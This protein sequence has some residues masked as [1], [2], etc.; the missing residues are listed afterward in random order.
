[1]TKVSR[2]SWLK[3]LAAIAGSAVGTRVAGGSWFPEAGAA[4]S[5]KA[6]VVS[7]FFEG[8]FNALFSS[9]DSFAG[10][11]AFG[12]T[13]S[14]AK[15]V[16]GGLVVD[17][18]TIGALGDWALGHMAAIGNRHSSTDHLSAQRNNF[19]D[20]AR[21]YALQLA[22]AIGIV[23]EELAQMGVADL[24]MMPAQGVPRPGGGDVGEDVHGGH[25]STL[26]GCDVTE[27]G[28]GASYGPDR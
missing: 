15:S 25:A 1:M 22:A 26:M 23:F 28:V 4:P 24:V 12:V 14:N 8:G 19:S 3:G 10:S 16:G 21:S 17:A 6:A 9:A 20:G 13:S 2:R 27:P 11:G 5:G 18:S 7:I